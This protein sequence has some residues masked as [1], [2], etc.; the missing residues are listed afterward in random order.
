MNKALR[1]FEKNEIQQ[2]Y[3]KWLSQR[4]NKHKTN[5][6]RILPFNEWIKKRM[7]NFYTPLKRIEDVFPNSLHVRNMDGT[8]DVVED[9]YHFFK[10]SM[11]DLK[12]I[13]TNE[14]PNNVEL[15]LRAVFNNSYSGQVLPRRFDK[16]IF[17][18]KPIIGTPTEYLKKYLPTKK[19][20]NEV[21]LSTEEDSNALV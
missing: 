8:N 14:S 6:G 16:F 2:I 4:D 10:L 13:R 18:N 12:L 9:F 3:I 5:E 17:K 20:L 11:N 1:E 15:L 7:P 21:L 19:D